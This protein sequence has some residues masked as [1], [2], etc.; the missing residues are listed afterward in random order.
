[1][2]PKER[3]SHSHRGGSLKSRISLPIYQNQF[4]KT[5]TG[6]LVRIFLLY[7]RNI[8]PFFTPEFIII[9][10]PSLSADSQQNCETRKK[11]SLTSI[12]VYIS[13][14]V[15]SATHKHRYNTGNRCGFALRV[16]DRTSAKML[17]YQRL[18]FDWQ[19]GK[20]SVR[21]TAHRKKFLCN[22]TN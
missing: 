19:T 12:M 10:H 8:P 11:G 17:W 9:W 4:Q 5:N 18:P 6:L 1:M 13:C 22:K 2:V 7:T 16:L 14:G 3:I 21:V 15:Y 20:I